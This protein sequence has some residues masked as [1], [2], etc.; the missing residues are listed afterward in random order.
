MV[1]FSLHWN[2]E[3]VGSNTIKGMPLQHDRTC[4]QGQRQAGKKQKNCSSMSFYVGSHQN[5]QSRISV[6]FPISNDSIKKIPNGHTQ[7]HG[8]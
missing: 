1:V 4:Q 8:F 6:G 5:W 7:L 2:P 3:G